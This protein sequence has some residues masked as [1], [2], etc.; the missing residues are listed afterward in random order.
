MSGRFWV[1]PTVSREHRQVTAQHD[2]DV[3][4]RAK[5]ALPQFNYDLKQIDEHLELVYV[6]SLTDVGATPLRAGYYHV[7]RRNPGAPVTVQVVE[8]P[9]GEFMEPT[10]AL[11][12]QLR[13]SDLWNGE[14][15]ARLRSRHERAAQ[16]ADRLK[17]RE[18]E[19]RAE[20]VADRFNALERPSVSMDR[21]RPWTAT[22]NGNGAR[23]SAEA[24]K[25]RE[26][27]AA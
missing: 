26:P 16:A 23:A 22:G 9:N 11:F 27:K 19:D 17:A 1:P 8:G 13:F 14:N 4:L 2:A 5:A 10:S 3:L 25:R 6:D 12:E 20:E 7:L 24:K 18:R 15:M 21:S